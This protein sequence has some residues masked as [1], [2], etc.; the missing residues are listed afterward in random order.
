MEWHHHHHHHHHRH[1][2]HLH[3]L[4]FQCYLLTWN[5]Y[6]MYR[7]VGPPYP[8]KLHLH[9]M[10]MFPRKRELVSW[11]LPP[12]ACSSSL[13]D[14]DGEMCRPQLHPYLHL[15]HLNPY[16]P[17]YLPLQIHSC[18][19]PAPHPNAT[20]CWHPISPVQRNPQTHLQARGLLAIRRLSSS[21][22]HGH[23]GSNPALA[24]PS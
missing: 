19:H 17:T 24:V 9:A 8:W 10:Q 4:S 20:A 11:T 1:R 5:V 14:L 3:H 23:P 2:L 22:E 6:L 21:R 7:L 13:R 15:H 12:A 16:L 18:P